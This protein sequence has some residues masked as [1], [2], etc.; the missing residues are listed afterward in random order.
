MLF[1]DNGF[2]IIEKTGKAKAYIAPPE[3]KKDDEE[4][5]VKEDKNASSNNNEEKVEKG[6]SK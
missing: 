4:E 5:E 3:E 1:R 6:E 2:L